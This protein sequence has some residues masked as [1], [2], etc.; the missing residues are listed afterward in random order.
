MSHVEDRCPICGYESLGYARPDVGLHLHEVRE[1]RKP[2]RWVELRSVPS[3]WGTATEDESKIK[4]WA[5]IDTLREEVAR[6]RALPK[7][8][9]S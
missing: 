9:A 3:P 8:Y 4:L 5:H 1:H 2:Q 6:L 7:R